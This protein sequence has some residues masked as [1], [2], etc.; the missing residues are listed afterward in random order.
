MRPM[1]RT[2]TLAL[3]LTA[4][5]VFSLTLS[6]PGALAQSAD[7]L[8]V[9]PGP[10]TVRENPSNGSPKVM[11]LKSGQRVRIDYEA[12]GWVAVFPPDQKNRAESS[13]LG[14]VRL[15]DLRLAGPLDLKRDPSGKDE[16]KA[17]EKAKE[18]EAD[19][20]KDK[21]KK[22][23]DKAKTAAERRKEAKAAKAEAERERKEAA[24]EAKAAKNV[25]EGKALK[26]TGGKGAVSRDEMPATPQQKATVRTASVVVEKPVDPEQR[27]AAKAALAEAKSEARPEAKAEA[28]P[29]A[30]AEAKP[31]PK[32]KPASP[33]PPPAPKEEDF[34]VIRM[35]DRPLAVRSART[36][37]SEFKKLLQ[38]GQKVRTDFH[39]DGFFAV[40][41]PEERVRDIKRAWGYGRDKYLFTEKE[42]AERGFHTPPS[43][44][45]PEAKAD[46]KPEA[47]PEP[48]PEPKPVGHSAPVEPRKPAP[49]P[50]HRNA[51]APA[52]VSSPV[53]TAAAPVAA[54]PA[55]AQPMPVP[56]VQEKKPAPAQAEPAP[57]PAPTS[58]SGDEV[59]GYSLLERREDP[60][61]PL[62]PVMLR[63]RLET[64]Q[65]PAQETL[66]RV[67]REIWK[68]ERRKADEVVMEVFLQ[69]M[70]STS[71]AYAV[72]RFGPDG[73]IR[74]LYWRDSLVPRKR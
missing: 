52:P 54:Q 17:S 48:K 43:P 63:V 31:A 2:L 66:R 23:S 69:G 67:V 30:K 39:S 38:P 28:K 9:A 19:K 11:S 13:A 15:S 72:A 29:E 7:R 20:E 47:K 12:D 44:A 59:L 40:F 3:V 57:A 61:R 45:K 5:A 32:A 50:E 51:T 26:V 73:K 41:A 10:V 27:A 8:R 60:L 55:P 74:E 36:K 34:G 37:D 16:P 25:K 56:S 71:L 24:K 18:K 1:R 46:D 70:D 53:A 21:D 68:G 62:A 14:Y 4:L 65:A 35:P 49:Q 22:K 42:L 64:A 6:L 33:P 58:A